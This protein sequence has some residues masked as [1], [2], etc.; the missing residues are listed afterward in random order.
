MFFF[1]FCDIEIWCDIEGYVGF[2]QVS[3][4]GRIRSL[5]KTITRNDGKLYF[6]K[7]R[8]LQPFYGKTSKYL[9]VQLSIR[10]KVKKYLIHRLVASHFI[11][12]RNETLEVNHI[13]GNIY[14]N[15]VSNLEYITHLDNI[16]HAINTGLTQQNGEHSVLAKLSNK[17]ANCIRCLCFNFKIKQKVIAR[18]FNV[19]KQTINSIV[20]FKTYK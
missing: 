18:L 8:I 5:D 19:S 20:N 13:D 14:N 10:N 15:H 2:Y 12:N 7:G 6:R 4:M 3:N 9:Q 11:E 17:Q 16:H 1:F